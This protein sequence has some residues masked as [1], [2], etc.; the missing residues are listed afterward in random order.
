MNMTWNM[1]FKMFLATLVVNVLGI[2]FAMFLFYHYA[3]E[4]SAK[5]LK[6]VKVNRTALNSIKSV[7]KNNN[8]SKKFKLYEKDY[9]YGHNDGGNTYSQCTV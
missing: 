5:I 9:A 7:I 2:A 6:T 1:R 3:T 8:N 4:H